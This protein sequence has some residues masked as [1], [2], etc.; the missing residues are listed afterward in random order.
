MLARGG[1]LLSFSGVLSP[2]LGSP[3]PPP[4]RSST[5]AV[6]RSPPHA[7]LQATEGSSHVVAARQ[8]AR[9]S[10]SRILQDGR[11]LTIP[12]LAARR[13]A[14]RELFPGT[15]PLPASHSG[16]HFSVLTSDMVP[17]LADVASDSGIV[18]R[19]EKGPPLEQISSLCAKERFEGTLAE[20]RAFAAQAEPSTSVHSVP[21]H[22][23]TR[24]GGAAR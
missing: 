1:L 4:H 15:S 7:P 18:S 3:D 9:I 19:G 2:V 23:E 16:S 20:A 6:S 12:E 10:P 24:D 14:A 21:G 22:R 13:A 8:S 11:I 5:P 17:H